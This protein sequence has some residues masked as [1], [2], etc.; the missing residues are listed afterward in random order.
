MHRLFDARLTNDT[1]AD[2][3]SASISATSI[4]RCSSTSATSRRCRRAT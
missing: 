1:F 3:G 2:P 4:A